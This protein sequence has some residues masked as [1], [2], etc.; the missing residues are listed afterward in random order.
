MLGLSNKDN[1]G[2]IMAN[3]EGVNKRHSN[4]TERTP[5]LHKDKTVS[6]GDFIRKRLKVVQQKQNQMGEMLMKKLNE[7]NKNKLV[8]MMR[9]MVAQ[10]V[11]ER[12]EFDI[13]FNFLRALKNFI[14]HFLFFFLGIFGT[15]II[16][17]IDGYQYT[18]NMGF[19]GG[20]WQFLI[21]QYL[22]QILFLGY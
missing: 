21:T 14:Y 5:E 18:K 2:E 15:I 7:D 19:I 9:S 20:H 12:E 10:K 11:V 8:T 1:T 22:T 6:D 13:D 3:R 16:I 17:L 4:K